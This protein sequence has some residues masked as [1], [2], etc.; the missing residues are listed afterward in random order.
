VTLVSEKVAEMSI[1]RENISYELDTIGGKSS[2]KGSGAVRIP[3]V[4]TGGGIHVLKA[5]IT[6]KPL[7]EVAVLP[8][9]VDVA[10]SLDV[11]EGDLA[12]RSGGAIDIM[13]GMDNLYLFPP[14][15]RILRED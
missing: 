1:D 9:H 8:P 11:P 6:N 12:A 10:Q 4:L 13:M 15:F 5:F 2:L 7:G 14:G 3:L